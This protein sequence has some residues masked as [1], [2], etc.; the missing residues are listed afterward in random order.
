MVALALE[1]FIFFIAPWIF[2]LKTSS[3]SPPRCGRDPLKKV[4]YFPIYF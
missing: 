1:G 4:G 3:V 2:G